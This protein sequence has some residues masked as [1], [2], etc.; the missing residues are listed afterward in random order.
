MHFLGLQGIGMPTIIAN[1]I[2]KNSLYI[3]KIFYLN[4]IYR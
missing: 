3:E 1:L 4:L 2:V